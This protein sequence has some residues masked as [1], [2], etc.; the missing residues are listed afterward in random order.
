MTS[1]V[2]SLICLAHEFHLDTLWLDL[3]FFQSRVMVNGVKWS[4][5]IPELIL[6]VFY[7]LLRSFNIRLFL[8]SFSFVCDFMCFLGLFSHTKIQ[9]VVSPEQHPNCI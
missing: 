4:V 1:S 8:T 2:L 5:I 9:K 7:Y 6:F 3:L